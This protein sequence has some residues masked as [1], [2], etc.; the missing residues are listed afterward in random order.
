MVEVTVQL[1]GI[2][3]LSFGIRIPDSVCLY[4]EHTLII[5]DGSGRRIPVPS[6]FNSA[7][8]NTLAAVAATT[9]F[10]VPLD[11]A[12]AAIEFSLPHRLEYVGS[13][14]GIRCYN[15]SKAPMHALEAALRSLQRPFAPSHSGLPTRWRI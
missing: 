9:I 1:G 12:L 14:Q 4:S 3:R 13:V 5:R 15:D 2:R 8:V 10:R 11:E 7:G 6:S